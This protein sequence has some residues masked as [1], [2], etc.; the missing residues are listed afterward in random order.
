M[1]TYLAIEADRTHR[2][3]TLC[4]LLWPD[5]AERLARR[6]LSQSIYNLQSTLN[7]QQS[8][9]PFLLVEQ[10]YVQFNRL[11][12]HWLD[13]NLLNDWSPTKPQFDA[14]TESTYNLE[15]IH[16]GV[17]R[18]LG[19]LLKGFSLDDSS[20]FEEW[21]LLRRERYSR[22]YVDML[23]HL[24]NAH[25][26]RQECELAIHYAHRWVE[27]DPYQED[28]H[29]LLIQMLAHVGRRS[30][31]VAQFERCSAILYNDLGVS[32]TSKTLLLMEQIRADKAVPTTDDKSPLA[33]GTITV[34]GNHV[35]APPPFIPA[36]Q[37]RVSIPLL[38]RKQEMAQ[39][40]A[41]YDEMLCGQGKVVFVTGEAGRGKSS[42]VKAFAEQMQARRQD[43]LVL[44]SSCNAHS[45]IGDPY[46]PFSDILSILTGDSPSACESRLCS[47]LQS[48]RLLDLFPS[49]LQTLIEVG[50]ELLDVLLPTLPLLK[51]IASLP[52]GNRLH[53]Q[54]QAVINRNYANAHATPTQQNLLM[55]QYMNVLERLAH[56]H[57][58][59]IVLD[60]LQW[61]D[62]NTIALLFHIGVRLKDL[63]ILIIGCY[64][65]SET[66]VGHTRGTVNGLHALPPVVDEFKRLFGKIEVTL[67]RDSDM[68]FVNALLDLMPNRFD[69][70]FRQMLDQQ[71]AGNPLFVIELVKSMQATG[72]LIQGQDG[73]WNLLSAAEWTSLPPR[74]EAVIDERI[75]RLPTHLRTLLE[76]AA[77][78]GD[79]FTVEVLARVLGIEDSEIV[80]LLS[81][82]LTHQYRLIRAQGVL[83]TGSR[84]VCLYSFRQPIFR[85]YL[86]N[87]LD[88]VERPLFQSAV[89]D[90]LDEVYGVRQ[91]TLLPT[92]EPL[93]TNEP[94]IKPST[95]H[96]IR[97]L[98]R[99]KVYW[100][101]SQNPMLLFCLL[102]K[103]LEWEWGAWELINW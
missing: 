60:D 99:V 20:A 81:G 102:F 13:V 61:A 6:S 74:V 56:S 30:E 67:S 26:Q 84:R 94:M 12:D 15:Y 54:L 25:R 68:E 89:A 31:A 80:H 1:L 21:L 57:P 52:G 46:A 39:L 76:V 82:A 66:L 24:V 75:R 44:C 88:E 73:F 48:A 29:Y 91:E 85:R 92:V 98:D 17:A 51:R 35:T 93:S 101:M 8:A 14:G 62:V 65:Q 42:L 100:H 49:V 9:P 18:Y 47:P 32:P 10:Q 63:P 50:P 3:E 72:R 34:I 45:G 58:L 37:A 64:R 78:E 2:R 86:Y 36:A 59:L 11:S 40:T 53:E 33:A 5:K 87:N 7:K 16:R 95:Q 69:L 27:C 96:F 55:T 70:N 83:F 22:I 28:A 79:T 103:V 38:A 97:L 19:D 71:T 23:R 4:G 41:F 90:A 43:L 77:I